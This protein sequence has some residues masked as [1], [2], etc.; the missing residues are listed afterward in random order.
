[1]KI[2]LAGPGTGKTTKIK[3]IITEHGNGA[4]FLVLSFTNATVKDLQGSLA[5]CGIS[6]KNC[7]TLHKFAVKYNPDRNKHVLLKK[8]INILEHISKG[9]GIEFSKLCVHLNCTTFE[10]MIIKF[11][12]YAKS[13]PLYLKENLKEYDTLIVDEYQDFNP[14]DQVLIDILIENI[15][16]SYLL[17]DDDQ[18]IYDFRDASSEKII[19]FYQ[20]KNNEKV[21]HDHVCYRCPDKIVEHATYLIAENKKRISKEW[22]KNGNQGD[23]V[24]SQVGNFEELAEMI[25]DEIVKISEDDILILTPAK[26]AVESIIKKFT[27]KKIQFTNFFID[28]VPDELIIKS[29]KARSVFGKFMYLNLIFLGYLNLSNRKRFYQ[30]LKKHYDNGVDY[31]ELLKFLEK[32]IP[33]YVKNNQ[34]SIEEF[35]S[36]N[37]LD[38]ILSLYVSAKGE[39]LD[40]KLENIFRAIEDVAEERIKIMSIHKSKGLGSDHVFMIGLNE[41]ILPN[42]QKGNDSM[43]SQRRLF[44]VGVTRTKKQLYLYS[45]IYIDGKNIF[46]NKLNKDDFNFDPRTKMYKGKASSFITELK[47][48]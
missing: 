26:F 38:D 27:E 11:I 32:N 1:M 18:C 25:F 7:M 12:D 37:S 2:L 8:E 16:N 44:Y 41:G 29:W 9:T 28:K 20:D 19:T 33:N 5:D 36:S 31:S 43:E 15:N 45:N 48:L 4:N 35:L 42:K 21:S 24:Y 17:G 22:K 10:Q 39:N 40:E 46:A 6:E 13:N 30:I 47:L 23:I 3:K 14:I 34:K